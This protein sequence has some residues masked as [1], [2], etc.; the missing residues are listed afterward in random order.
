MRTAPILAALTIAV[1]LLSPGVSVVDSH[2]GGPVAPPPGP[3]WFLQVNACVPEG[4]P[5]REL[6]AF[7]KD[8]IEEFVETEFGVQIEVLPPVTVTH[9]PPDGVPPAGQKKFTPNEF[10]D[11]TCAPGEL[12]INCAALRAELV[13]N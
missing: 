12:E 5:V 1:V 3:R 7:C 11:L 4:T 2:A 13:D 8:V 10:C 9:C 6:R